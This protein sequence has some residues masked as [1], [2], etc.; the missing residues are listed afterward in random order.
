MKSMK[1]MKAMKAM[2]TM[3]KVMKK[4]VKSYKKASFVKRLVFSGKFLK[5]KGGLKKD[6]LIKNK[7]GRIVSKKTSVFA[8]K[9]KWIAACTKARAALKIKGFAVV[10]GSSAS[11]K[12]LLAKAR[13][14]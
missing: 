7:H 14:F 12:A 9:N 10:G 2:K 4:T 6:A 3:K 13:S 11:G 8:K 5:T 1:A